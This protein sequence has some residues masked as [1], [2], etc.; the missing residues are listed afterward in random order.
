[1]ASSE[2]CSTIA[3]KT[4]SSQLSDN[5]SYKVSV[6]GRSGI[7]FMTNRTQQAQLEGFLSFRMHRRAMTPQ[8]LVGNQSES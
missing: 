2:S 4:A 1:L 6:Q 8:E 3:P 7:K 5:I